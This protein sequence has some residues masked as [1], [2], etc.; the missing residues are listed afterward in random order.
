MKD[1]IKV[2]LKQELFGFSPIPP[3]IVKKIIPVNRNAHFAKIKGSLQQALSDVNEKTKKLTET[4]ESIDVPQNVILTFKENIDINERLALKSLDSHGMTLLS[5]NKIDGKIV[6]NVSIPKSRLEKLKE[7]IDD[8]GTK[9]YGKKNAP[10]NKALVESISE[11]EYGDIGSMWFSNKALPT[12]KN[13]ILNVEIWLDSSVKN[14]IDLQDELSV[15]A[16]LIGITVVNGSLSFKDRIVKIVCASVNQLNFLQLS[17][18]SIAEIRP[19]NTVSLDFLNL[20][21]TEQFQW[22][23]NLTYTR[24]DNCIPVCILDTGVTYGHPLLE[25]FTNSDCVITAEL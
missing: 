11:I 10:K 25:Q 12:D 7:L 2:S 16:G 15:A 17:M 13:K 22:A 5:V 23:N 14:S 6:A 9:E 20:Q 19:A 1:H 24:S 18:Q 4:L 21:A 3:R 8:Y